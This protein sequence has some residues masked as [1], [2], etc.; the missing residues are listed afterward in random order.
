VSDL[1][2]GVQVWSSD[3]W[4]RR[5]TSW[6]D[7]RLA[8]AGLARTGEVEQPRV[9]PWATLLRAPTSGG[10]V[11]LKA[12]GRDTAFEAGLYELLARVAPE[13]LLVPL[14]VDAGRGWILLPDA[15][16]SLGERV[17]GSAL[18]EGLAAAL[19]QYGQLQR[20][21]IPHAG[22][23]FA[24]GLSDMR[25]QR[26]P[27][28]FEEALGAVEAYLEHRGGADDHTT[29]W[30]VAGMRETV[31][32][33]CEQLEAAPVAASVEHN[34]LHTYNILVGQDGQA[35]FYDWGDSVVAHPFASMGLGLGF[36]QN[37]VE[38]GEIERLRDAYLEVFSDLG[39]HR[40][41]VETLELAC[42]VGKVARAL[43]W[44]RAIGALGWDEVDEDWARGPIESMDSLL[45]DS[46]LGRT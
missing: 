35:R 36:V 37:Q 29:Y 46:Y 39:S 42:R 4:R 1:D 32:R 25:P 14:A 11:W 7:E 24:L 40:E 2:R 34:D 18:V 27:D 16:L 15:G 28:R 23:L 12:T 26:M 19:P 45:D 5:A 17:S 8:E 6:L 22:D 9:R 30:R 38:S 21:L 41:L 43:T 13:R 44:Q 31:I 20:D 10:P 3:A 33:W